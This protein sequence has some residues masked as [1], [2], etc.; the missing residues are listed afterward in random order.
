MIAKT[1]GVWI[2]IL[3]LGCASAPTPM[4]DM[5]NKMRLLEDSSKDRKPAEVATMEAEIS[6]LAEKNRESLLEALKNGSV[7]RRASAA[8]A[9]G[10]IKDREIVAPL[11]DALADTDNIVRINAAL[12]LGMLGFEDT[13]IELLKILLDDGDA[14]VRS[15]ATYAFIY[16]LREGKDSG[17]YERLLQ[18]LNDGSIDVRAHVILALGTIGRKDAMQVIADKGTTDKSPL[19]RSNAAIVLGSFKDKSA[20]PYLIEMLRDDDHRVVYSASVSLIKI[21]GEDHGR[22]YSK[23]RD[24]WEDLEKRRKADE[25]AKELEAKQSANKT[26]SKLQPAPIEGKPKSSDK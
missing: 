23:W 12:S 22:S 6:N 3:L 26:D 13:P 20:N 4:E 24:W 16:I 18:L 5:Y 14:S 25:K 9:L 2:F 8:A 10:Y 7:N 17:L 11:V 15:A 1:I 19:V 21:N